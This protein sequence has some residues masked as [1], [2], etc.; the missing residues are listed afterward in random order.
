MG[1]VCPRC[2]TGNPKSARFCRNC[3]LLLTRGVGGVLGAGRAPH[4]APLTAPQGFAEVASAAHLHFASEAVGGGAPLLS[5]EPLLLK[6]FN[7]GYDLVEVVVRVCS[8]DRG[9]RE[10]AAAEHEVRALPRGGQ[11]AVEVP[12]YELPDRVRALKVELVKAEFAPSG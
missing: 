4:P 9:G 2:G 10:L 3:G 12:S 11:V 1:V 7:G 5:T 6:L 8:V